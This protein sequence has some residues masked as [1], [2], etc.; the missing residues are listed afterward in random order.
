[1]AKR[2]KRKPN[3]TGRNEGD[4]QYLPIPYVMARSQAF[5]SLSGPAL[6]VWI[7]LRTRYNGSNNGFVSLSLREAASLLGMSQSTAQRGVVELEE[8]GF[9]KKLFAGS[10][11]GR[12][13]AEYILTDK[14]FQGYPPT[15]DWQH[16]RPKNRSS[17]PRRTAK[18]ASGS[19]GYR[20]SELLSR[21]SSRRASFK[22]IDG[23]A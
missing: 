21:Q 20:G 1:M 17:V 8:K 11:Y 4:G 15:K 3:A 9:I 2:R 19:P 10:W 6:K 22:V 18:G 12:K 16:W 14:S 13:A 5:R 23:A 7:E